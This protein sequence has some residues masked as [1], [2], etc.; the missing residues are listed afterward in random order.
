MSKNLKIGSM[1]LTIPEHSSEIGRALERLQNEYESG[2]MKALFC[3]FAVE[4]GVAV[5]LAGNKMLMPFVAIAAN[6]VSENIIDEIA[7]AF[8]SPEQE[9]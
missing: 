3:V 7:T 5:A 4:D 6:A 8:M 9:D 2:K 1:K